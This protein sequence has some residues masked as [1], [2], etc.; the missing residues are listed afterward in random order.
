[1]SLFCYIYS[2]SWIKIKQPRR[3]LNI[4]ECN[5]PILQTHV[6]TVGDGKMAKY[7]MYG[8]QAAAVAMRACYEVTHKHYN[9]CSIRRE[10]L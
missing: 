3:Q 10:G 2:M 8:A 9:L 4:A 1:M 6:L 7:G 5:F